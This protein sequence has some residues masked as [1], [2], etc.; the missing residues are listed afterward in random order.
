MHTFKG[1]PLHAC[2][3]FPTKSTTIMIFPSWVKTCPYCG[4][5]LDANQRRDNSNAPKTD[6][7]H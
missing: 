7:G 1:I 5:K 4:E 3:K 6:D 2:E